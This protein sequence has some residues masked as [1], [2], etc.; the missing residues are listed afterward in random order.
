MLLRDL[1]LTVDAVETWL[2]LRRDVVVRGDDGSGRTSVLC[3]LRDRLAARGRPVLLLMAAGPRPH[4]ALLGHPDFPPALAHGSPI[5]LVRWLVEELSAEDAVL[6][7]D[8]VHQVDAGSA[9]AVHQALVQTGAQYVLT[10]GGQRVEA[11]AETFIAEMLSG[12][13]PAD[14]RVRPLGF[15]SLSSLVAQNLGAPGDVPLLASVA[16]RS[17]GNPRVAIALVDAARY[18]G[19]I[20][21]RNGRWHTAASVDHVPLDAVVNAFVPRLTRSELDALEVLSWTGPLP[22]DVA[23]RI[24]GVTVLRGLSDRGRVLS[25]PDGDGV[26]CLV[27]SPPALASALRFGMSSHR[28]NEI[29][30][31]AGSIDPRF[32][33]AALDS[34]SALDTLLSP[35]PD[36]VGRGALWTA[37]LAAQVEEHD[38]AREVTLRSAWI[39]HPCVRTA[40]PYLTLLGRRPAHEEIGEVIRQTPVRGDDDVVER[41]LYRQQ[42]LFWA[43]WSGQSRLM[44]EELSRRHADDLALM[45][46]IDAMRD[47][48]QRRIREDESLDPVW[49]RLP[50]HGEGSLAALTLV[51]AAG[52]LLE[53][54]RPDLALPLAERGDLT[55]QGGKIGHL[56]AGL[57]S[58]S[59]LM[60]G[61]WEDVEQ[62]SRALLEL[63]CAELDAE[64]IRV[65]GCIL[66]EVLFLSG[67]TEQAWV[68][69]STVL[70]FGLAG[71]GEDPFYRRALALAVSIRA[72]MGDLVLAE[73]LLTELR[74][75][76]ARH[77]PPIHSLL[78]LAEVAM[79][80]QQ[81][82]GAMD[83]ELWEEGL[84]LAERGQAGIA[85]ECWLLRPRPYTPEQMTVIEEQFSRAVMPMLLPWYQV[86]QALTQGDPEQIRSAL[87]GLP[88]Q[89]VLGDHAARAIGVGGPAPTLLGASRVL[90]EPEREVAELAHRGLDDREIAAKLFLSLRTTQLHLRSAL[91]KLGLAD[92]GELARAILI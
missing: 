20:E 70:R 79:A 14:V 84:R 50:V 63:A 60:L 23:S 27:V 80:G 26:A 58:S 33:S 15:T 28:R 18:A 35:L 38:V 2:A 53:A 11:E 88:Q 92:R 83:Q 13:A 91:D 85:L 48:I 77:R 12:R 39:A 89:A 31:Q 86:H 57:R 54:G 52:A 68:A 7:I 1:E 41:M 49:G 87:T 21:L 81:E 82:D 51:A 76:P 10:A 62:Q 67:R 16:A 78:P 72:R 24:L 65:H 5:E 8:D 61:E 9:E 66:S 73:E 69:V 40:L 90:T 3:A 36:E 75:M 37:D 47:E 19:A 4:A 22:M 30:E 25:S 43:Q 64:G 32:R 6:L 56:L 17:G 46:Q 59:L 71:P 55:G 74:S 42:H 29:A 45:E 34:R 44:V